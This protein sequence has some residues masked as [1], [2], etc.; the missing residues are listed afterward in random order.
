[1]RATGAA[2]RGGRKTGHSRRAT[3]LATPA[4]ENTAPE[5]AREVAGFQPIAVEPVDAQKW[6]VN[7]FV[8]LQPEL[9]AA[10]PNSSGL[11]ME[12]RSKIPMPGF[13]RME[14]AP[15]SPPRSA[16]A[17]PEFASPEL[18]PAYPAGDLTPLGWDPRALLVSKLAVSKKDSQ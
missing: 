18:P 13:A 2:P 6:P 9:P 8:W 16:P 10:I 15:S 1:M 14:P 12:R 5:G 17:T 4:V 11:W 7:P 3:P